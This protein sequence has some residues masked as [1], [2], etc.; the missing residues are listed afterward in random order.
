[1]GPDPSG[2]ASAGI[3]TD[4][5]KMRGSF[6]NTADAGNTPR[7]YHLTQMDAAA[8][9]KGNH[10]RR[11]GGLQVRLAASGAWH[12][13]GCSPCATNSRRWT[14]GTFSLAV[15]GQDRRAHGQL[16][17]EA[18]K[19]HAS[20]G[21]NVRAQR[22]RRDLMKEIPGRCATGDAQ[23]VCFRPCRSASAWRLPTLRPP[24]LRR[25][26]P[27]CQSRRSKPAARN[28]C[29]RPASDRRAPFKG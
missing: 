18:P 27:A 11:R 16:P 28:A 14:P 21:G 2:N 25:G 22:A 8:D 24:V 20:P 29:L 6:E 3:A 10:S 15:Q 12:A 19:G 7:F 26:S 1:M 23:A 17:S 4:S 13:R 9:A 5:A